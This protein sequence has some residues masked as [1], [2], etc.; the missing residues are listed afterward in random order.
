MVDEVWN[1]LGQ[2]EFIHRM[3][4]MDTAEIRGKLCSIRD[5]L[6]AAGCVVNLTGSAPALKN[7]LSL[8][9]KGIFVPPRPRNPLSAA[10]DSFA[11]L[12]DNSP[13]T[14]SPAGAEVYASPSLQVGF[15]ARTF[16]A[17][18]YDSPGQAGEIVLAHLLST[19]A[20][21]EDIRMKGGAYG[22]FASPDNLEG[23]Y[24]FST[25]RDPN[26]LRSLDSFENIVKAGGEFQDD[27]V[28]KAVIG[29]YARETRP[30][31]PAEKGLTDFSRFLYGIEDSHRARKLERIIKV[32]G[33]QITAALERLAAQTLSAPVIVAGTA[34]AEKAAAKLGTDVK[35][36][37]V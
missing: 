1:G 24:A 5:T 20:L 27:E 25:Y 13:E 14:A 7:A 23:Y 11:S 17:A 29:C 22:A 6:A 33:E 31:S 15:A 19:G 34:L 30:R 16:T 32:R 3:A 36:L 4:D 9:Q 2:I 26:P 37:P 21:W 18:P 10:A 35:V 12:L 28:E 8:M